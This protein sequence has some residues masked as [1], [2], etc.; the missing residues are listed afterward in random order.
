MPSDS[1]GGWSS[2]LLSRELRS[3]LRTARP[4]WILFFFLALLVGTGLLSWGQLRLAWSPASDNTAAMRRMF[5]TLA[6]GHLY[7]L[8]FFIPFLTAPAVVGERENGTLEL[9]LSSPLSTAQVIV[10]KLL[11]PLGFVFLLLLAGAPVLALCLI[12]GGLSLQEI[13]SV[14]HY[15]LRITLAYGALGLFCS[16]LF[17]KTWQVM[18]ATAFLT[19]FLVV[20]LPYHGSLWQLIRPLFFWSTD[21][22]HWAAFLS[23]RFQGLYEMN[24][25]L[26]ILNP[27]VAFGSMHRLNTPVTNPSAALAGFLNLEAQ[28]LLF[29]YFAFKRMQHATV[30]PPVRPWRAR[31]REEDEIRRPSLF[32]RDLTRDFPG[33]FA[34]GNENAGPLLEQ[35]LQWFA[36]S[37][38][39]IR[40]GYTGVIFSFLIL[41]IAAYESTLVFFAFPFLFTLLFTLPVTATRI[42]VER[43]QGT[44]DL[45]RTTLLPMRDFVQAK[46]KTCLSYSLVCAYSLYLPGMIARLLYGWAGGPRAV[47]AYKAHDTIVLLL[48]PLFLY[49]VIRFYTA[50]ALLGS[51]WFRRSSRA[52]MFIG[53]AVMLTIVLPFLGFTLGVSPPPLLPRGTTIPVD[54]PFRVGFGT[55]GKLAFLFAPVV[56]F[57]ALMPRNQLKMVGFHFPEAVGFPFVPL[58]KNQLPLEAYAFVAAQAAVLILGS[59]WFTRL[60]V[61]AMIRHDEG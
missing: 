18:L 38:G 55:L 40:M 58:V 32:F 56:G 27:F 29:S 16:T 23:E 3:F 34:A 1:R 26:L 57:L 41:P 15:F 20:G 2:P 14:Y 61:R 28:A 52:L 12:G 17:A 13:A 49:G 21:R 43:E 37:P 59:V 50:L 45:L 44:L 5:F 51:A 35:R 22:Y 31:P 42:G 47:F 36:R 19:L 30:F 10:A 53:A 7:F 4:F 6:Q 24:H 48:F 60:T 33:R 8:V 11:A 9:L 54:S 46:Y 39:L 25:G